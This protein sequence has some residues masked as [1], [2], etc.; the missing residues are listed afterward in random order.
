MWCEIVNM[1]V[2]ICMYVCM[3]VCLYVCMQEQTQQIQPWMDTI[4]TWMD[5]CIAHR[6]PI[7]MILIIL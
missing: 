3:Y 2:Y 6:I 7:L 1:Y 4:Q 5:T